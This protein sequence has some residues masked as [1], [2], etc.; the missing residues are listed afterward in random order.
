MNF[1][2]PVTTKSGMVSA[3]A[4]VAY[5]DAGVAAAEKQLQAARAR[6]QESTANNVMAQAD[7]T[8][9]RSLIAQGIVSQQQYDQAGIS[10]FCIVGAML[11]KK[12]TTKMPVHHG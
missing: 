8:R 5:S 4:N 9:N 1:T 10:L 6:L 11:L 12:V 2:S 7:L 3:S